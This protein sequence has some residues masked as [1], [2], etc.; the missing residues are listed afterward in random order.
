MTMGNAR[1][2]PAPKNNNE[3]KNGFESD[4]VAL[5]ELN[6]Q[7]LTVSRRIWCTESLTGGLDAGTKKSHV[8]IQQRLGDLED[9]YHLN[10]I[11]LL[12]PRF[13]VQTFI[14]AARHD[15][16]QLPSSFAIHLLKFAFY[17]RTKNLKVH[18]RKIPVRQT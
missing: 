6:G 14:R 2:I 4:D 1:V 5:Y 11:L 10:P 8:S 16:G 15:L 12:P 13:I 9:W 18:R 3:N 7:P 17:F